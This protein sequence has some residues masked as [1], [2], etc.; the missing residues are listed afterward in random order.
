MVRLGKEYI[1]FLNGIF[2]YYFC[3]LY[4]DCGLYVIRGQ[5]ERKR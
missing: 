2:R 4:Y 1:G 3:Y 5:M